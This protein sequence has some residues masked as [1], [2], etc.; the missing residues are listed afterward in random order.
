M[1]VAKP[2]GGRKLGACGE[3][4]KKLRLTTKDTKGTKVHTK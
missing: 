2:I 4:E 3:R 1:I